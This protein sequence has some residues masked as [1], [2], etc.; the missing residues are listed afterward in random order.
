MSKD[1]FYVS[2]VN[3]PD[4]SRSNQSVKVTSDGVD[5]LDFTIPSNSSITFVRAI[6]AAKIAALAVDMTDFGATVKVNDDTTPLFTMD[7]GTTSAGGNYTWN[8]LGANP[9][10]STALAELFIHNKSTTQAAHGRLTIQYNQ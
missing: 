10:G 3:A 2:Q 8:G 5:E 4:G 6:A 1:I 7:I 9:F